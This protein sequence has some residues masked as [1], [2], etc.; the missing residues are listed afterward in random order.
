MAYYKFNFM[1]NK[2]FLL[3]LSAALK[4][5][6]ILWNRDRFVTSMIKIELVFG[7]LFNV[8][9]CFTTWYYYTSNHLPILRQS[10]GFVQIE[11]IHHFLLSKTRVLIIEKCNFKTWVAKYS[12][13]AQCYKVINLQ[14]LI[15]WAL[16]GYFKYFYAPK[17]PFLK[18]TLYIFR[19]LTVCI[20]VEIYAIYAGF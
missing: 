16:F 14:Y 12:D 4:E 1:A 11:T 3:F 18:V 9:R 17:S 8:A 10:T 15:I 13:K 5:S 6:R 20:T 7:S 19:Q 2:E